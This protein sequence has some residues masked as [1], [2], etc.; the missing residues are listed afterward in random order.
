[1]SYEEIQKTIEGMLAV[2]RELQESQLKLKESQLLHDQQIDRL[3]GYQETTS[4]QIGQLT[5]LIQTL[6]N[7]ANSQE[8]RIERLEQ[9]S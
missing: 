2:Q 7:V 6:A 3:I 4:R 9:N 5:T 1:M 8:K